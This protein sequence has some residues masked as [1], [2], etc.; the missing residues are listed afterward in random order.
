MN[1]RFRFIP[2]V[3]IVALVATTCLA[4]PSANAATKTKV[5]AEW[6]TS[7]DVSGGQFSRSGVLDVAARRNGG[8]FAVGIVGGT[9]K[10]GST[11]LRGPDGVGV[12]QF[13]GRLDS[14]GRWKWA[15]VTAGGQTLQ[16]SVAAAPDGGAYV[17]SVETFTQQ[18][19]RLDLPYGFIAKYSATGE[20]EWVSTVGA[21]QFAGCSSLAVAPDG[22]VFATGEGW[23]PGESSGSGTAY[24]AKIASNGAWQWFTLMGGSRG[25]GSGIT[26]LS[27]GTV[28]ATGR[29]KVSGAFGSTT[30]SDESTDG[31]T[32]PG[33]AFYGNGYVV[34]LDPQ[35]GVVTDVEHLASPNL[36]WPSSIAGTVNGSY[37]VAGTFREEFSV[38]N[39]TE[40]GPTRVDNR[41]FLAYRGGSGNWKWS[42]SV[43][44]P[45]G[46]GSFNAVTFTG[47]KRILAGGDF[48]ID[49][50]GIIALK[51]TG[52]QLKSVVWRNGEADIDSLSS[53]GGRGFVVGGF[54]FGDWKLSKKVQLMGTGTSGTGYVANFK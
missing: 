21:G 34:A 27:D 18:G 51:T 54:Q 48:G 43:G 40:D 23:R 47:D 13:V 15:V 14:K 11:T 22:S 7:I 19:D 6:G 49:K 8:A 3:A 39:L 29:F 32:T 50:N 2:L 1:R 24:V 35:S 28:A 5:K 30:L 4:A 33:G 45:N 41:G 44:E 46:G 17:C 10:F 36:V 38:G 25:A 26:V 9:G 16:Q 20:E 53:T 52:R 12:N 42:T 31:S 37:V